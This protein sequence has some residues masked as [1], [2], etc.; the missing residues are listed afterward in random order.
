ME[1]LTRKRRLDVASELETIIDLF[2]KNKEVSFKEVKVLSEFSDPESQK[3]WAVYRL[4]ELIRMGEVV[5]IKY[6]SYK[7]LNNSAK[8]D[9]S[10]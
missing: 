7:H 6:G 5:K 2:R 10:R 1:L 9:L 4:R 8:K 3:K